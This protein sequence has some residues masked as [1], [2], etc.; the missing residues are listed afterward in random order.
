MED[1]AV[2]QASEEE[3]AARVAV[4]N[5]LLTK[6]KDR[7][8]LIIASHAEE[9]LV[10]TAYAGY[11]ITV[12]EGTRTVDRARRQILRIMGF[13]VPTLD[14]IPPTTRRNEVA[15]YPSLRVRMSIISSRLLPRMSRHPRTTSTSSS[16]IAPQVTGAPMTGGPWSSPP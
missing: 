4:D 14:S 10:G 15:P 8:A 11:T 7:A 9:L 2:F 3:R 5:G 12:T 1:F 13:L 16:S 6:A